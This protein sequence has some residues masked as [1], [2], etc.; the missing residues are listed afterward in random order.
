MIFNKETGINL[1]YFHIYF[2][3]KDFRSN[4]LNN[5]EDVAFNGPICE[6]M[7]NQKY[8]NGIGNYLR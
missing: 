6:T 1:F 7:L 4:I 8:F 3:W 2:L 5:L